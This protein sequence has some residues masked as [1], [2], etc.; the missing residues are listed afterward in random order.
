MINPK[1][2]ITTETVNR[3]PAL[4]G[5]NVSIGGGILLIR[6]LRQGMFNRSHKPTQEAS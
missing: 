3:S 2:N 4:V 5:G 1:T 6:F